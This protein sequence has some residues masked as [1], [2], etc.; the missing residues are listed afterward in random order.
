MPLGGQLD[1]HEVQSPEG[2]HRNRCPSEDSQTPT[3]CKVQKGVIET[4]AP[5]RTVRHP[6]GAKSRRESS[7]QMP[8]GGQSD[9]HEVQS[10]EGSHRNR[11]PSEDSQTPTRCKVQ[12]GVIET[13]AP[14]RTVRHPR[15][16]CYERRSSRRR[17]PS[18]FLQLDT[19]VVHVM[20][21]R[22][23]P[24]SNF[25]QLCMKEGRPEDALLPIFYS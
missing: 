6:R 20:S 9:T 18:N 22:R 1:T 19:H 11:C 14:R 15:G 8:L 3:R 10:P 13:D 7:K 12:K 17:P 25:L 23:R 21:S 16:A 2:S 24:P 5:R 4:D